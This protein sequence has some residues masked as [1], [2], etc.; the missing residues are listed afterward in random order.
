M[1]KC[2]SKTVMYDPKSE[3]KDVTYR[4]INKG[5][6]LGDIDMQL[7]DFTLQMRCLESSATKLVGGAVAF[8]AVL[9]SLI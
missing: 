8:S 2:C 4:C 3:T 5:I 7:G 9:A 1:T 6:V